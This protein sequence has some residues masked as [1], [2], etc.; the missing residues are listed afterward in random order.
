MVEEEEEVEAPI[1][2][3]V[4]LISFAPE[5]ISVICRCWPSLLWGILTIFLSY[6]ECQVVLWI[7]NVALLRMFGQVLR[8]NFLISLLCVAKMGCWPYI[9]YVFPNCCDCL[10]FEK[11]EGLVSVFECWSWGACTFKN[12]VF[13]VLDC[14]W[15]TFDLFTSKPQKN[16]FDEMHS[17]EFY[18]LDFCVCWT[19]SNQI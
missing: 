18:W 12:V 3:L 17:K 7:L 4:S 15:Q 14:L 11:L 8:D 9:W 10:V 2:V 13:G 5:F 19:N 6:T 16:V 1:E